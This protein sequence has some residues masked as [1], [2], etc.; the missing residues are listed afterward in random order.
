MS[1]KVCTKCKE[2]KPLFEFGKHCNSPD[3]HNWR[4][5]KCCTDASK[6]RYDDNPPK[7]VKKQREYR[8][9]NPEKSKAQAARFRSGPAHGKANGW[10]EAQMKKQGNKCIIC[11][12]HAEADE[13]FHIDHDH[14]CCPGRRS[15][16][17]C[18]RGILCSKCNL[19]LGF[20]EDSDWVSKAQE[21]LTNW[22][23]GVL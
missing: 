12:R 3:G 16:G 7:F 14:N 11:G 13:R 5:K 22:K 18:V 4:C 2:K 15:C 10:Y 19:R 17:K 6:I 1:S 23:L 9:A 21:Y 20:P 8:L